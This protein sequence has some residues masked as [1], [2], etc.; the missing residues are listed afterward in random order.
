MQVSTFLKKVA[1]K[2]AGLCNSMTYPK[3]QYKK[4]STY[5]FV[6]LDI[7]VYQMDGKRQG[8]LKSE[9]ELGC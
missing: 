3:K 4:N 2:H 8:E 9:Y 1:L 7:N 5:T 6:S